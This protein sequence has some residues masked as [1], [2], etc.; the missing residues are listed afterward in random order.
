[1]ILQWCCIILNHIE[2]PS[3]QKISKVCQVAKK[4]LPCRCFISCSRAWIN[5]GLSDSSWLSS[6]FA[7]EPVE[8]PGPCPQTQHPRLTWPE[9][10]TH[11]G[12]WITLRLLEASACMCC[13]QK[14][15]QRANTNVSSDKVFDAW[16]IQMNPDGQERGTRQKS[17][18]TNVRCAF[19]LKR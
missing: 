14:N 7:V 16:S 2:S 8:P 17:V 4:V 18:K 9:D 6:A 10:D 5:Q 13:F 11:S 3:I 15:L 1:M 19:S 12:F